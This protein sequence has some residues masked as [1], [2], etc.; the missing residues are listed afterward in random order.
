M[1]LA[2]VTL[3]LALILVAA[4]PA[5]SQFPA[6]D[7]TVSEDIRNASYPD[8]VPLDTLDIRTAPGRITP[9]TVKTMEARVARLKAR[10]ARLRGTVIDRDT[11]TRMQDGIAS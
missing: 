10:A 6:L 11:H 9:G 4:L 2:P 1:R 7:A 3:P 8:L 5:C